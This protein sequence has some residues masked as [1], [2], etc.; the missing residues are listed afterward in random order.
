MIYVLFLSLVLHLDAVD[1]QQVRFNS[2]NKCCILKKC[3]FDLCHL[4]LFMLHVFV[5]LQDTKLL[6]VLW[7]LI[8]LEMLITLFR[9]IFYILGFIFAVHFLCLNSRY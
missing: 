2:I 6:Q 1:A 5:V 8:L 3:C 7:V 4:G 9:R